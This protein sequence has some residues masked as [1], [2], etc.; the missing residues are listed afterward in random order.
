MFK[1]PFVWPE[2]YRR[3]GELSILF[4]FDENSRFASATLGGAT[5]GVLYQR[6]SVSPTR[7]WPDPYLDLDGIA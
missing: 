3:D 6:V 7:L 5:V 2:Q 1:P 4:L